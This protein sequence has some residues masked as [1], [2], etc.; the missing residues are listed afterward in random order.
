V[1]VLRDLRHA[2]R[3]LSRAPRFSAAAVLILAVGIGANCAIFSLI[4]AVLLRPLTGVGAP[5]ALVSLRGDTLSYPQYRMLATEARATLR[6]AASQVRAMS[7]VDAGEPEVVGGA[8]ASGNYFDVLGAKPALGRFFGS[9]EE[10]GFHPVV[11]LSHRLWRERFGGDAAAVGRTVRLNGIP[12]EIVG[13]A[14]AG[15]RGVEF[16]AYPDLWVTIG[17]MPRLATG[18]LARLDIHSRNWGWLTL[19]GRLEPAATRAAA[20]SAVATILRRDASAHGEPFDQSVWSLVP[21][22]ADAA[23]LAGKESTGGVFAILAAAVAAALLIACANLANLLLARAAVRARE[24]A[25]RRAL[26]AS[27]ARLVGQ[28][29]SESVLLA[30]AGG[31]LG[32][33]AASWALSGLS[34]LGLWGEVTLG[35]FEPQIGVRVAAFAL[36][37]SGLTGVAFG[38][39]PALHASRA[40]IDSVLRS[41]AST[42]APR[43]LARGIFLGAQVAMCLALLAC[44]GLLGRSIASAL[45]IDLG[46]RPTG[47]TLAKVRLGLQRYDATRAAAFVE[48]LPRRLSARPAV[49]AVS[50]TGILPLSGEESIETFEAGGYAP[51][52]G[53]KLA[54]HVAL[55]GAGY[56]RTLQVPLVEGREFEASDRLDASP[57][58][59]V[60]EAMAK[61]YWPGGS[62]IGRSLTF[63]RPRRIVGVVHDARFGSLSAGAEPYAF[64]PIL[65]YPTGSLDD[66]TLLVRADVPP[67]V[68]AGWIRAA[69]RELDASVPVTAVQPYA[70]VIGE[71]LLPQRAGAALLGIFGA[72]SLLLA[73]FGIYAVVSYSVAQRTREVGI[74]IALGASQSSVRALVVRQSATPIL[75]GLVAGVA[76]A[77]A[78]ARLLAGLLYGVPPHDPITFGAAVLLL[79]ASGLAA[80]WFPARRASRVD[81]IAAIRT[82]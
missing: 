7:L 18:G 17:A 14:P 62:P 82:E 34:G 9:S 53:E 6:L 71:L 43:S 28:M 61:R 46:F 48:E 59:V 26:G 78:A 24:I 41:T 79:A 27:R 10:E 75:I 25:I 65:Q 69:V 11:V 66:L 39:L 38:L 57:V 12:F 49:T 81:P 56:F 20:S 51:A 76:M 32:L 5:E 30:L 29:L 47:V 77:A 42:L 80:A 73:A 55:V 16:G 70:E 2:L 52:T 67:A 19:F 37:A 15:F 3:S 68:A 54:T 23:G 8:L 31:A 45:A 21:T 63:D 72:L 13:V 36:V 64:A 44:A 35:I 60:N 74:R 50:W 4:D 58:A 22:R 33:L 1:T 40:P